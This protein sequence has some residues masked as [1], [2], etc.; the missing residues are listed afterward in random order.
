M[1]IRSV[2]LFR[3]GRRGLGQSL[4]EFTILLPILLIMLS[5]LI[6]LGLMLNI[7]LD[8]IDAARESARFA[9]DADPIRHPVTQAY[10]DPNPQFYTDVQT[11]TKEALRSSSDSR[12]DWLPP[13]DDCALDMAGN[14][15]IVISAFAAMDGVVTSRFPAGSPNGLSLCTHMNSEWTTA[16]IQARLDPLAPTTGLVLVE[17]FYDYHMALG[18]PWITAFVGDPVT[19]HAYSIMP[20]VNVEPTATP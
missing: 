12:I 20:N 7:Y 15:D 16:E 8:L 13:H 14:N 11:L 18:L 1:K 6:E 4:V 3:R 5:G 17:I 2:R 19:L 10:L 9:A